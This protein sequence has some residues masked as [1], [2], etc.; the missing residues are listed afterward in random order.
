[1]AS[2]FA[3]IDIS[4]LQ[5]DISPEIGA[6]AEKDIS[7]NIIR[8]K[9]TINVNAIESDITSIDTPTLPTHDHTMLSSFPGPDPVDAEVISNNKI[10]PQ[11]MFPRLVF[12]WSMRTCIINA[13]EFF[14]SQV[15][16]IPS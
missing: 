5:A 2:L 8:E 6:G 7:S 1:M 15:S 10:R 11:G 12:W 13:L 16:V 4:L 3:G 9:T 14:L